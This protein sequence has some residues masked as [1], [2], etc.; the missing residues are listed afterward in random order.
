MTPAKWF[1]AL[2][3]IYAGHFFVHAQ[4]VEYGGLTW[5]LDY[6]QAKKK[7]IAEGKPIVI[8]F[9]E[10]DW[11]AA[12][13]ALHKEVLSNKIFQKYAA[14]VVLVLVDYPRRKSLNPEQKQKNRALMSRFLGN[15]SV[16]TMVGI[17]PHT[18]KVISRIIGYNYY[19]HNIRPHIEFIKKLAQSSH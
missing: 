4:T 14:D 18:G 6:E 1:L 11:C 13:I 7:A 19:T 12:C 2:I 17:D 9:T 10:S 15:N 3:M 5:Y 16:P 8:L